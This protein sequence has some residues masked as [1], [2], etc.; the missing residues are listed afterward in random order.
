MIDIKNIVKIYKLGEIEVAALNGVSCRI[1][2]GQ[3]VSIMGPSGSGKST[4]MN[5]IGCL[6][7]PTSGTY[8]L[9]GTDVSTLN[10]N[11]LA[12]IRNKKI[13]FVFQSYNLLPQATA[14]ANVELPLVYSGLGNKRQ[15]AFEALELV[16]MANRARHRPSE[17]SGGE[18]QRVAIARA[19]VNKPSLILADE[20][21]GN[22]DTKTSQDIMLLLQQLNSQ[23][24][25]I[26]LVTHEED[27][28]AYTQRTIYLRD[29]EIVTEKKR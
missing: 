14:V 15:R 11:Q 4:L 27:I 3:I 29:G 5:L 9:D 6:D 13:G 2:T 22:L 21:T 12:E 24:I 20:P 7:R 23:G 25:T 28:A 8:E 10:D 18:Q 19:L 1:E 16:G 17:I 26:V